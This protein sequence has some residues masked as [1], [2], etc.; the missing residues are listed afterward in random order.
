M[1]QLVITL[2]VFLFGFLFVALIANEYE[3]KGVQSFAWFVVIM[4]VFSLMVV[5]IGDA[6]ANYG[7]SFV[8][9][10]G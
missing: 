6:I 3:K 5:T 4:L 9:C 2:I 10:R 1:E 8:S 7:N